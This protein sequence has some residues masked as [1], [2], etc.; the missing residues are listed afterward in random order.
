MRVLIHTDEYY[1]TAQ[2]CS[3][4][5]QIMA[6]AFRK[7]GAEVTVICSAANLENGNPAQ[8]SERIIYSPAIRMKKKTTF[9]RLL[10]NLSFGI[11]S[12]ISSLK[13]GEVDLVMTTSPPPLSSIPGWIIAKLKGAKLVYD[14][15]DIWPDVAVEMGSFAEGSLYYNVF[16]FI[17]KFMYKHAD[18]ITT[19][20]SGK[21]SKIQEYVKNAER[22]Q[23]GK[24]SSDKVW[25]VGNGYD[26]Q[27]ESFGIN[28]ELIQKYGLEKTFTCVYVGNIGLAQ[29]LEV[30]LNVASETRHK[31]VQFLIFGK[32]AEKEMLEKIA[33][34]RGLDQVKFCG[35]LPHEDI[36]TLLKYAKL[37]FIPLKNGK[38]KDSIPTKLYE[39]LGIG[40]PVLLVAEG[41]ACRVLDETKLGRHLSP[42][43]PEEITA[44]FD[45]ILDNYEEIVRFREYSKELI[46]NKYTRQQIAHTFTSRIQNK[47]IR[48][49]ITH[50]F[51][52]KTQN[53]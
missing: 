44:V 43:H 29:G 13:I 5:M 9:M 8:G 49:Q 12:I 34:E 11:T 36:Y 35:V 47:Y 39:A 18:V 2:A 21:V 33:E 23:K 1:P 10:N 46:H 4:R 14:V 22:K 53:S 31:E 24:S 19:V 15:R 37:S 52:T 26:M 27:V 41:D 50:T 3:Y 45:E 20:S 42:D 40:C 28:E 16:R 6:E 32:G 17:A 38:M 25:L 30:L 51:T 7:N 48:Q